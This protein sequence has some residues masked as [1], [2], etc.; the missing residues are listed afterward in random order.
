MS[1]GRKRQWEDVFP[2]TFSN[3][4]KIVMIRLPL[5]VARKLDGAHIDAEKM[6]VEAIE[7]G[8]AK[9]EIMPAYNWRYHPVHCKLSGST[10]AA[11]ASE[12][13][14]ADSSL[15]GQFAGLLIAKLMDI[16]VPPI[17]GWAANASDNKE[18]REIEA[19]FRSAMR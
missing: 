16:F 13:N 5:G 4:E 6:I 19:M 12:F 18:M 14:D 7:R 10:Y 1:T 8:F 11:L 3:T 2:Q 15:I 17:S 9:K